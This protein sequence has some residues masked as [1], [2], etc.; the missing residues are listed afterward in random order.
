MHG[1]RRF[2]NNTT[3]EGGQ[4]QREDSERRHAP[5]PA[6]QIYDCLLPVT[7]NS[8][9]S[10]LFCTYDSI[11]QSALHIYTHTENTSS[12]VKHTRQTRYTRAPCDNC[13]P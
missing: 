2:S 4:R 12:H 11:S 9:P 1:V 3:L 6:Y 8:D 13:T 5:D 7:D 10:P